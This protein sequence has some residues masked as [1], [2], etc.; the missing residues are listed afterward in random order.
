MPVLLIFIYACV[1]HIYVTH[2]PQ[3]NPAISVAEVGLLDFKTQSRAGGNRLG[4]D[5]EQSEA[6]IGELHTP[7]A[8]KL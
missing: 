2:K 6:Y 5:H 1:V 4:S 3:T 7:V 8:E